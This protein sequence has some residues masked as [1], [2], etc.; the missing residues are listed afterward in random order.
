MQQ[1]LWKQNAG[2][3][4][5]QDSS[6]GSSGSAQSPI[7]TS[8]FADAFSRHQL[9]PT[10]PNLSPTARSQAPTI[11]AEPQ[12]APHNPAYITP[13]SMQGVVNP[14]ALQGPPQWPNSNF[15][16]FDEMDMMGPSD[17]TSLSFDDQLS[18]PM[19]NRQIPINCVTSASFMDTKSDYEDFNQFLNPNPTEITS[20]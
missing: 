2:H 10:P 9:P 14:I 1:E 19:F 17:F 6:D 8:R 7:T 5:R 18:S 12:M 4:Q 11:K 20:M 3:M 15:G 13:M 16:T